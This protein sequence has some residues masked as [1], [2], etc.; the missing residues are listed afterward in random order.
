M[1]SVHLFR[2]QVFTELE[3]R[4]SIAIASNAW[5]SNGHPP[6]SDPPL[7][8][9]IIDRITYDAYIITTGTGSYRLRTTT[10]RRQACGTTLPNTEGSP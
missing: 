6:F 3:E 7:C 1:Q 5:F 8:A 10:A 9:A 4:A 2:F